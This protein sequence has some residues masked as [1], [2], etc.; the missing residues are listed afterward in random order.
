MN[1]SKALGQKHHL[2]SCRSPW[3]GPKNASWLFPAICFPIVWCRLCLR[4]GCVNSWC[5]LVGGVWLVF[6]KYVQKPSSLSRTLQKKELLKSQEE[7]LYKP[8]GFCDVSGGSKLV[9]RVCIPQTP[10]LLD[11]KNL[12]SMVVSG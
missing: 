8:M 6:G 1:F 9:S 12:F 7:H 11:S 3:F 10:D 4:V 2:A 5:W